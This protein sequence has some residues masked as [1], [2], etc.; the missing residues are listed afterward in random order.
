MPDARSHQ[1]DPIAWCGFIALCFMALCWH[2]LGIP[3]KPF[4]DEVHYL[5]AARQLLELIPANREHPLF[6]KEILA[7]SLTLL[8]DNPLGW[9]LPSLLLGGLGLFA[10][11]RLIWW[12]SRRRFAALAGMIL[13]ASNFSWFIHSRISMLDVFAASF[14]LVALWQFAAAVHPATRHARLRLAISGIFL[15]LAIGSKWSVVPLALAPGLA[16][17]DIRLRHRELKISRGR[18]GPIPG[19][20]IAEAACCLGLLPL[21]VYW[22]SFAPAYFYLNDA[23]APGPMG[24][25]EQH[26]QMLE[27]QSGLTTPHPYQSAWYQ[28]LLNLRPVWYLYEQID[29]AQRGILLLGNPFTMLAGLPALLWCLWAG[30]WRKRRDALAMALLFCISLGLWLVPAKPIQFYYH[31]LVPS[32]FLMGCLALSLDALLR[33]GDRWRAVPMAVTALS[34]AIF[35][36]FYPILSAAVLHDGAGAFAHWMWLDSWQ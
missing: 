21:A 23:M 28:W 14:A 36:W 29:G 16:F 13:L 26:R 12:M 19:M 6:G 31:Y 18:A 2:R 22:A 30:I 1:R 20:T 34:I 15:G 4:F 33:A 10:F 25:I 35:V 3:T 24:L 5:P 9:R 8:G 7:A 27:L 32:I 17:L 11:G